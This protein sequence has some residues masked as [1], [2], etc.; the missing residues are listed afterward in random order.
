[1]LKGKRL[2]NDQMTSGG[3]SHYVIS[4]SGRTYRILDKKY[5]A[6]HAG[7]SIWNGETDISK[8]SIGIELVGYHYAPISENQTGGLEK[9]TADANAAQKILFEPKPNWDRPGPMI[10][11]YGQ[12]S[13]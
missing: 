8:I 2:R 12:A 11:M 9:I 3:H 1:M 7:L 6:D 13:F 10:Q 4:R 5:E